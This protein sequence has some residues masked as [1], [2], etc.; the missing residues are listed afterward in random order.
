MSKNSLP[1]LII[2]SG[3]LFSAC[4]SGTPANNPVVSQNSQ[5]TPKNLTCAVS[6]KHT[7]ILNKI[8][9]YLDVLGLPNTALEA[10]LTGPGIIG[11][12]KQSAQTEQHGKTELIWNVNKKGFYKVSATGKINGQDAGKCSIETNVK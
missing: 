7:Q 9:I 1:L 3:F 5:S 2:F 4:Q 11:E 12:K 10:E 8:T 6:F